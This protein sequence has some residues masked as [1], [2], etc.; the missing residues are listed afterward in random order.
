MNTLA[1]KMKKE[2]KIDVLL[3]PRPL[4]LA[5]Y[6]KNDEKSLN[7]KGLGTSETLVFTKFS[8]HCVGHSFLFPKWAR[9]CFYHV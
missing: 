7:F 5:E 9:L 3:G 1:D 2:T 4:Y 8:F 6:A